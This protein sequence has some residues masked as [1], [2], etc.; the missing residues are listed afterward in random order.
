M[1]KS[2]PARRN[3]GSLASPGTPGGVCVGSGLTAKVFARFT[4]SGL[5]GSTAGQSLYESNCFFLFGHAESADM[6]IEIFGELR[7][8]TAGLGGTGRIGREFHGWN[9]L[10]SGGVGKNFCVCDNEWT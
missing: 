2:F 9:S 1:E 8:R 6:L 5:R 7:R 4:A 3:E 10:E